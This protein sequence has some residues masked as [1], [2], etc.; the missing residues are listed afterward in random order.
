[1]AL[2][3]EEAS[4]AIEAIEATEAIE[5]IEAIEGPLG[6]YYPSYRVAICLVCCYN[7]LQFGQALEKF[8]MN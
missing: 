7:V 5:A 8:T 3:K 2:A 1:L 6:I 4:E